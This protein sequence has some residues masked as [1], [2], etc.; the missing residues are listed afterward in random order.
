[1]SFNPIVGRGP[2]ALPLFRI[3]GIVAA[4]LLAM[5]AMATPTVSLTASAYEDFFSQPS[6]GQAMQG[7]SDAVPFGGFGW[8]VVPHHIGLGAD[9]QV[10]FLKDSS[11]SWW[12][13]WYSD[14]LYMSFHLFG[15][16]AWLDP[17]VR[18]GIG[19]AGRVFLKGDAGNSPRLTISL[20]PLFGAG[21]A[22]RL[23][24]LRL[25]VL[26]NGTPYQGTIPVT[27]ISAYPLG[28]FQV[29]IFAGLTIR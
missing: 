21:L 29:G 7:F 20:F 23:D 28:A 9:Y 6:I 13:D 26:I 19:S 5:P 27:D 14:G 8:E 17:F 12:L 22:L 10:K 25:G 15:G 11:S 4:A 16:A 3:L 24:S 18:G 2:K 1:M